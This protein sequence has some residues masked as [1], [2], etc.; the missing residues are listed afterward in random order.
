MVK[1][2]YTG[3]KE[4]NFMN[5]IAQCCGILV[6]LVILYFFLSQKKLKLHT[7]R[8]FLEIWGS[9]MI[10]LIFDIFSIIVIEHRDVMSIHMVHGICK[11]YLWTVTWEAMT[12]LWYICVDIFN[13]DVIENKWKYRIW[14]GAL[15]ADFLIM[16][17][18]IH[19]YDKGD[20]TYTYGPAVLA[21]Y[22]IAVI[23]LLAVLILISKHR[24]SMNPRRR[25]GVIAWL[26]LWM[27]AALIQFINNDI[28]IVGFAS[29]LGI[30]IIYLMLENPMANIDRDTGLFNLNALFE[31]MKE[32]QGRMRDVSVLCVR[33]DNNR[34]S[35]F[36]Y[37]IENNIAMEV[38]DYIAGT[39]KATTFR[40]S[41]SEF[42]LVFDNVEDAHKG[43]KR[44]ADRFDMPWGVDNM[45]MLPL[46]MYCIETTENVLRSTDILSIFQYAKQNR[47]EFPCEDAVIIDNAVVER[48]YDEKS[49]ENE[50][51]DALNEDRVEVFYQPIFCTRRRCFTT[52]EALVRI[53]SR[54]G[55][56]IPP[57]RFIGIAEKRGLI[58]RLGERVFEKVCQFIVDNDIHKLGLEYIEINLSVIQCAYENLARD[59]IEIMDKYSID[60]ND[61]VLEITESASVLEKQILLQNMNEL[62]KIGVRF[63][64]DDFGTGQSN[65]NY[66]VDMPID[67]VKFDRGMTS[68]YFA[69]GKGKPVMDAAMGMIQ[70]LELEIVSEGIEQKEQ[71]NKLDEMGIDYI[72][73]YYFS[74]P[75][76]GKEFISFIKNE[77]NN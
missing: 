25:K 5:V 50:I 52:A 30:L 48:I 60:P 49:V 29:M 12:A 42:I 13:S 2:Y 15:I 18:P 55:E 58:I 38:V 21:T 33:Y 39:P 7:S 75:R 34:N 47:A 10:A 68:A 22:I 11:L 24:N 1:W 51:I 37:E 76:D 59:F 14:G 20:S 65:L 71:F 61:I 73:G 31:Y 69:N 62:R 53:K 4:G 26:T 23:H 17:L 46:E 9:V 27:V 36:S 43:I 66:I 63:A 64:L 67:I 41:T 6:M 57:G 19:I 56:I 77:N 28:L 16:Y 44:I 32:L 40:S 35:I 8:A 54:D 45:R 72:Q 74:K 3:I 70:K